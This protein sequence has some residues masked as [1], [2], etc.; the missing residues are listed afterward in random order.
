[1]RK[2]TH[3]FPCVG[4]SI[5]DASL[6]EKAFDDHELQC[7]CEA[8]QALYPHVCKWLQSRDWERDR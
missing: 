3:K 4:D 8:A 5:D 6:G 7:V 2:M 1:M